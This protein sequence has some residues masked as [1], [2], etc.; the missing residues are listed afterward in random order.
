MK[1]NRKIQI[2]LILG[3]HGVKGALRLRSLTTDPEAIFSY[4]K[5]SDESGKRIFKFKRKGTVRS[6]FIVSLDGITD[7]NSAE[8]L[9][10][11]KLFINRKDL[12][13]TKEHEHYE[14][15]LVG[16]I[17]IGEKGKKY[18]KVTAL[19]DHGAGAFLEIKPSGKPSFMLPFNDV[20]VPEIDYK[21][22]CL[23]VFVPE[24][25]ISSKDTPLKKKKYGK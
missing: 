2:G 24:G 14:A 8:A 22:G 23:R 16:L 18:G 4:K 17:A 3:A 25:W 13:H 11:T 5:I 10:G 21:K 15:D 7:R 19:H 12:P 6:N 9:R 1:P 20:F